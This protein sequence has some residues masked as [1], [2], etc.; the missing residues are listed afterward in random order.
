VAKSKAPP[1]RPG[2]LRR[3]FERAVLGLAI[4]FVTFVLERRLRKAL[5]RVTKRRPDSST[6]ELRR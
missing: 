4:G 6:A 5:G 1:K 2:R 3:W